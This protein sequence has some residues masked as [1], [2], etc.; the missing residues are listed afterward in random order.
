MSYQV[1]GGVGAY[2][3]TVDAGR[4]ASGR[5]GNVFAHVALD[6][7]PIAARAD[8][9][10]VLAF[11]GLAGALRAGARGRGH[12][13]GS[14]AAAAQPRHQCGVGLVGFCSAATSTVRVFRVLLLDAVAQ[15]ISGGPSVVLLT[16]GHENS[17]QWIAAVSFFLPAS[18]Y[19]GVLVDHPRRPR[20]RR[21]RRQPWCAPDR[22]GRRR[23]RAGRPAGAVVIDE[24][25]V[26]DLGDELG[27][28]VARGRVPVGVLSTLA[29]GVLADEEIAIRGTRPL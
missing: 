3:H 27:T 29:E 18:G 1:I 16:D 15:A 4:D 20:L 10:I 24:S 22:D 21:D 23:A 13:R 2:W 28:G 6:R 7:R 5:P 11:A 8:R 25:E 19:A 9:P 17:A 26:P 14:G 12:P